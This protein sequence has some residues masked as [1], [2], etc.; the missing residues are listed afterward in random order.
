MK[1]LITNDDGVNSSGILAAKR[2]V[3]NLGEVTII[4]PAT[5]QS[6]IGRALTLFEPIR[7]YEINLKDGSEA[8]SVSGTP[9]D[10]ILVGIFRILKKKPDLVISGINLGANIGVGEL[11]TSGTIGAAI[12]AAVNGIPAISVSLEVEKSDLKFHD[13][14]IDINFHEAEKITRKV[15]EHI[16]TYGLPEESDL[17]NLNIPLKLISSDIKPAKLGKRMYHVNIEKRSDPQRKTILL[18]R[19]TTNRKIHQKYRRRNTKKTKTTH[20][21]TNKT[22]QHLILKKMKKWLSKSEE[23]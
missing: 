17:L 18:D 9:T 21:N 3:E 7:V 23:N 8:Y 15:A 13:G 2:A 14:D 19:W 11:T 10:C 4:A 12:E 20:N 22:R 6:G 16:L 1:I 5:Q